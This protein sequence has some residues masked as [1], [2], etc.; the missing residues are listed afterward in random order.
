MTF[1]DFDM[2]RL[3]ANRDCPHTDPVVMEVR[4]NHDTGNPQGVLQAIERLRRERVQL[5]DVQQV[6]IDLQEIGALF[7]LGAASLEDFMRQTEQGIDAVLVMQHY[8]GAADISS[9]RL[10]KLIEAGHLEVANDLFGSFFDKIPHTDEGNALEMMACAFLDLAECPAYG[11][12]IY[13]CRSA[14]SKLQRTD[15]PCTYEFIATQLGRFL[16]QDGQPEAARATLRD[17][18][19]P[20]ELIEARLA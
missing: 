17:A 11:M 13:L 7:E 18:G 14:L 5:N 19:I 1:K 6:T 12:A 2:Q 3:H 15:A 10:R 20:E 4:R 8:A 9:W 16:A